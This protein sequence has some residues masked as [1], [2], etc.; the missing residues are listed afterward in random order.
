[1]T[2]SPRAAGDPGTPWL[3]E[4]VGAFLLYVTLTFL[5]TASTWED[6]SRHW[7]GI[8]CDQQQS[9]W[10][11]AWLPTAIEVGQNPLLTDRLNA[12]DGANLMWNTFSPVISLLVLPITRAAGPILAYNVAALLAIA[13]SGLACYAALRRYT[14]RPLGALVGGA[15]YALSPYVAS[16]TT[17]HLNLINVWAPPLILIL[18]DELVARRRYAPARLGVALGVVGAL[19][20]VTAEEVLATSAIAGV[21]LLLVLALIVRERVA[22]VAAARRLAIGGAAGLGVFLVLAGFPLA[23]QF[24]GPQQVHGRVQATTV[25]STD[26]LNVILPTPYQLLAPRAVTDLSSH[27]SG[28]Y[29]EATGYIGL[30]LL[31]VLAW[32]VATR[33]RDP[34][35]LVAAVM[36]LLLL[37]LSFGPELY[38]GGASTHVPMPW[39]PIGNLPVIEHVLA[40]RLTLFMWLCVAALVA[41]SIDHAA[42]LDRRTAGASLAAVAVG[43]V[44]VLPAPARSST[45]EVPPFFTSWTKQGIADDAV[46]LFA[47]W[48]T[49]GAGADPMLWASFAEARPRIYEGYV[50]VP[51][52]EGRPRYGPAPGRLGQL[53]IE[54][55]DHG[56]SPVLS[57]ADRAGAAQELTEA[58]ISVVIVGPTSHREQMVGLFTD[59]FGQPPEETGGVQLWRD[60]QRLVT[61]P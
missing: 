4:L 31:L 9:M 38:I 1:V 46:I 29:H 37:V 61:Q 44:F 51:D 45:T 48:F 11:L 30:P 16:H 14:Q 3:R 32:F 27:F 60:V 21:L 35:V 28:L 40:G 43:L 25:F 39:L 50:Y 19:Q 7:I 59:L 34:R 49:N 5:F 8:C 42:T 15:L 47:P 23:V 54:V 58:G 26:L 33:R 6:P 24:F 22:I 41:M 52:A 12:P 56:T 20:F 55:Q 10:F 13:T 17:L 36:G 53:M 2:G 18:L 57:E